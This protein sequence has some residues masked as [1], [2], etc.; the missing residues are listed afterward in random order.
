MHK[1]NL[2]KEAKGRDCQVDE[3]L[4]RWRPIKEFV[5]IYEISNFGRVRS[6]SRYVNANGGERL[7]EG[8][9][10]K[11]NYSGN[12]PSVCLCDGKKEVTRSI[13][14]LLA[15]AFIPGNG[16]V[17][18]HLDGNPL[19]YSLDNLAW[20]SYKDNEDDKKLHGTAT[21]GETHGNSKLNDE[22]V[23]KIREFRKNGY[24]QMEIA[25]TL[26]VG[27]VSVWNVLNNRSWVHVK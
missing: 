26:N 6:I 2:R 15:L 5:G 19:N 13:H 27:R 8:R 14:R 16:E 10:I 12:Y 22:L 3:N 1:T 9:I 11:I 18:R 25:R 7:V 20:G 17:V 21:R 24:S 23:R 4:E